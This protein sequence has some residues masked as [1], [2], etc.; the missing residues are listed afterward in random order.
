[1]SYV[2]QLQKQIGDMKSTVNVDTA[3]GTEWALIGMK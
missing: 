3:G 2:Q 1:M